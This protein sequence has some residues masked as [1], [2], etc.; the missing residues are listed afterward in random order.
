MTATLRYGRTCSAANNCVTSMVA[1][2]MTKQRMIINPTPPTPPS[3]HSGMMQRGPALR[4]RIQPEQQK[5]RRQHHR[6]VRQTILER[7]LHPFSTKV[8]RL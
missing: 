2:G 6:A 7:L 5:Q 4:V 8:A 1:I 3:R